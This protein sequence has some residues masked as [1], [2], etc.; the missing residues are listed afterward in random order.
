ME[1]YVWSNIE[2]PDTWFG[3]S[4]TANPFRTEAEAREDAEYHGW[5]PG[6]YTVKLR[7]PLKQSQR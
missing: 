6:E 2:N 1:R 4:R 3:I 7:E 5:K